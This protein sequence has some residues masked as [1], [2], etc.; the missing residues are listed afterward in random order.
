MDRRRFLRSAG[1]GIAATGFALSSSWPRFLTRAFGDEGSGAEAGPRERTVELAEA[2]ARARRDGKPVLVLVVPADENDR[3]ARGRVLG[4]LI[5]HGGAGVLDDLLVCELA[6]A[7]LAEAQRLL[8]M[9]VKGDPAMLLVDLD[10]E[11]GEFLPAT[12][13]DLPVGPGWTRGEAEDE[14]TIRARIA[15]GAA[16]LHAAVAPS[17]RT[18]GLRALRNRAA[19]SAV[20]RDFLR[21]GLAGLVSIGPELARRG[22]AVLVVDGADAAPEPRA[23]ARAALDEAAAS[24]IVRARPAGAQW[25]RTAGCGVTIEGE[26]PAGVRCGMGRVPALSQRF[27]HFYAKP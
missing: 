24:A 16:A 2:V 5:N 13:I 1:L 18:L 15:A 10:V 22:A 11:G 20:E 26:P 19:L 14:P 17:P 23:R 21:D 9:D 4:E 7:T 8:P 3:Y 6:C 27:L 25:G 12:S